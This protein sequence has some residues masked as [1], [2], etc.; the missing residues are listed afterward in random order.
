VRGV[1]LGHECDSYIYLLP[2]ATLGRAR[3]FRWQSSAVVDPVDH[4]LVSA[5]GLADHH[6]VPGAGEGEGVD[7]VIPEPS[8]DVVR[9]QRISGLGMRQ[10]VRDQMQHPQA[11]TSWGMRAVNGEIGRAHV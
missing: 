5:P 1:V 7:P 10:G 2:E 11:L 4:I 3:L 8:K 6:R 9:A